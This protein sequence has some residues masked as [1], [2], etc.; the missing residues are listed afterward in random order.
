[1]NPLSGLKGFNGS[2][3]VVRLPSVCLKGVV[4]S[5]EFYHGVLLALNPGLPWVLWPTTYGNWPNYDI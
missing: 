3:Q 4:A 5:T 2:G 1:L